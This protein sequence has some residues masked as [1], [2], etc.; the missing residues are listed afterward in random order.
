[1]YRTFTLTGLTS[2]G[3]GYQS[4]LTLLQTNNFI[5]NIGEMLVSAVNYQAIIPD[6]VMQLD[7]RPADANTVD[8]T[9]RDQQAS[10]G[11]AQVL[12]GFEKR[13]TRNSISLHD[14]QFACA[15]PAA[16]ALVVEIETL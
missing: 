8:I 15:T 1:M 3:T 12:T 14:Y 7:V 16:Q 9:Y 4:I 5:N 11:T 10:P 2:A 6:R 13:S